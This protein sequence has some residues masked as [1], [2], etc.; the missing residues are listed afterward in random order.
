MACSQDPFGNRGSKAANDGTVLQVKGPNDRL[1]SGA[2]GRT[3]QG[4]RK[5]SSYC[6]ADVKSATTFSAR[7]SMLTVGS[8]DTKSRTRVIGNG[9]LT[10]TA[11][12][13]RAAR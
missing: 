3:L 12:S 10:S 2:L 5:V 7:L 4:T 1:I 13:R 9:K 11:L 8:A 6:E